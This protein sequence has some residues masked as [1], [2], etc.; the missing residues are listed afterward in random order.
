MPVR[1]K[2]VKLI[3]FQNS[4]INEI[5]M[6]LL[7]LLEGCLASITPGKD[8]YNVMNQESLQVLKPLIHLVQKREILAWMFKDAA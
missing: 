1:P 4:S 7:P 2:H 8:G 6:L 5:P 3:R